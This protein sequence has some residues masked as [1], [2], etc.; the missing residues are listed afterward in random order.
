MP[1]YRVT[2]PPPRLEMVGVPLMIRSPPVAVPAAMLLAAL[3]TTEVTVE[4]P[5]VTFWDTSRL[6]SKVAM[7]TSPAELMP[8]GLTVPIIRSSESRV[9]AVQTASG[10]DV[11]VI[12]CMVE[13][14]GS[15]QQSQAGSAKIAAWAVLNDSRAI[16]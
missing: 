6:P 12:A 13:G 14:N 3:R 1:E 11:D 8:E 10:Q 15:V 5:E 7:E 16:E 9:Q 2:R 4:V